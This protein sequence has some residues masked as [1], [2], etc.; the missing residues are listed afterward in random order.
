MVE[1][2]EHGSLL[3]G[4]GPQV[5]IDH[6]SPRTGVD[7]IAHRTIGFKRRNQK[8]AAGGKPMGGRERT[9]R[10]RER[11][12]RPLGVPRSA[13]APPSV[14]LQAPT[15]RQ[16]GWFVPEP[17]AHRL[18]QKSALGRRVEG[19]IV[20]TAE[21]VLFCHWYRHLPLPSEEAWFS[22]TLKNDTN[23]IRRAIA[24]D[25]LRNGG[26]R[27]V[28]VVNLVD[29]FGPFPSRTWA[30]RWERHEPW[31]THAGHTQVR[32]QRTQDPL[33]W[34]ELSS[35][36]TEVRSM[37]HLAELCVIDDEY[38]TTVYHLEFIEPT[39]HHLDIS[40]LTEEDQSSVRSLCAA[41][42]PVEGGVFLSVDSGWPLP[43]IG[44]PHFSGRFL[45]KEEHD[46]LLGADEEVNGLYAGLV[47]AGLLLRPGFKY[48]CR[49]RAYEDDI[50]VAHAPWLIQPREE[51][52]A[53][54]EEVCL[55]VRLAEG[56][57]KRWLCAHRS[58]NESAFLN[59]KRVG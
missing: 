11:T 12:T 31:S 19:G 46:H 22:S 59:I 24:L 36:V 27:V 38:D 29:R 21:E 14:P 53:T 41:A 15:K 44:V 49:W 3:G 17:L 57:N 47:E 58:E 28:P 20:L 30:I 35:W 13:N 39:G 18:H 45:R 1:Q 10:P 32:I 43:A 5:S 8:Q 50:E 2:V 34:T 48:G 37:N 33:D 4:E 40:A 7:P 56:V 16:D 6:R 52:P 51:A 42:T 26:E 54:W 23:L 25:V 55:S 9:Y